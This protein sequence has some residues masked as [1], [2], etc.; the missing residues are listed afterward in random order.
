M[1]NASVSMPKKI[2][3]YRTHNRPISSEISPDI[4]AAATSN[5]SKLKIPNFEVNAAAV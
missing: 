2:L 1:P 5:I 3:V 4:S